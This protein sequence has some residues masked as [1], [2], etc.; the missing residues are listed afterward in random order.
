MTRSV[1]A[2]ESTVGRQIR[3]KRR[4]LG[5]RQSELA[6]AIGISAPRLSEIE[7]GKVLP[8][9]ALLRRA[10]AE[11]AERERMKDIPV[12][13]SA[14]RALPHPLAV[15]RTERGWS[16][17][18]LARR[19]AARIGGP[20]ER[21]KVWRWE[22]RSVVP[23]ETTQRALA[24]E[25]GVPVDRL[26][27]QPWPTWLPGREGVDV[28]TPWTTPAAVA[29]LDSTV[30]EALVDR[31][32]FLTLG[33]E[34]AAVLAANWP[35]AEH[36]P[37]AAAATRDGTAEDLVASL[38]LRLPT[39]RSLDDLHGG[40][41]AR[42]VID[43][44]LRTVTEVLKQGVLRGSVERR[45]F[46]VAGELARIAGW[47]S[48]DIG[49]KA[50]AERY[51]VTGL[52]AAHAAEDRALGANI[53]K[54]TA[55]LMIESERAHDALVLADAARQATCS[56]PSRVQAMLAV[57]QARIHA[58]L[59]DGPQCDALL[60]QAEDLLDQALGRDDH[61]AYVNYFGPA[62][63]TAQ[64][65]ACHLVLGRHDASTRLLESAV[66]DQPRSRA[67]DL[68]TYRL[69]Q[70][71]SA[72]ALGEVEHACV[73]LGETAPAVAAESSTRNRARLASVRTLLRPYEGTPA[74]RDLDER[75]RDL[76]A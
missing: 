37:G 10:R 72:L 21:G 69:W 7:T 59:H 61:P 42:S 25:L 62:E 64:T 29:A 70:A 45:L 39:L 26:F 40:G 32:T 33:A 16:Q 8:E 44:E 74:V 50:S 47:A 38:E 3:Q 58:V 20:R 6:A 36:V 18:E 24:V 63:L 52:R 68:T 71:E 43:A 73:L 65:A 12:D 4:A 51:F 30:G 27:S 67:R 49:M 19:I 9:L 55:L 23:D 57:R 14:R 35:G 2:Y 53:I 13:T 46:Q 5:L 60:G 15:V 48:F 41:A 22:N 1:P 76:I 34:S 56:A 54:C 11:L 66:R 75:T 28:D 31:R 17:E